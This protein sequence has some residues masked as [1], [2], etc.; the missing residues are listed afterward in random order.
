ML[1]GFRGANRRL[2]GLREN[3]TESTRFQFTRVAMGSCRFSKKA[4]YGERTCLSVSRPVIAASVVT[5]S[6]VSGVP[7]K[8]PHAA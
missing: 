8:S 3:I 4:C 7:K 6:C 5:A 1:G 2:C